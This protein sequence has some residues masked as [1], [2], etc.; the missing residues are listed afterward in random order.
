MSFET[1]TQQFDVVGS[2]Y[3]AEHHADERHRYLL[4]TEKNAI[5]GAMAWLAFY[6]TAIVATVISNIHKV[7]DIVMAAL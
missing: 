2:G 6:T 1:H 4:E 5:G 7:A 3:V